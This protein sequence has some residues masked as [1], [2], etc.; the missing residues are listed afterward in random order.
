MT[1]NTA[2]TATRKVEHFV[3]CLIQFRRSEK[4][5]HNSFIIKSSRFFL[6][7]FTHLH[8]TPSFNVLW[9]FQTSE[10]KDDLLA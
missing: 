3:Y 7:E 10:S 8:L 1:T 2:L 9:M 4:D 5:A 6:E